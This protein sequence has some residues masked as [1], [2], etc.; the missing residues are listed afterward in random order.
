MK[1]DGIG[2]RNFLITLLRLGVFG[3]AS[4]VG[5]K[6]DEGF[7]LGK[8]QDY[9]LGMTEASGVCGMGMGCAGGGSAQGTGQCGM[10]MGCAGAGGGQGTGQCGMGMGC[11]GQ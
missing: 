6:K 2:R 10:G 11:A 7:H 4:I 8:M 1:E 3:I 5:F 9:R